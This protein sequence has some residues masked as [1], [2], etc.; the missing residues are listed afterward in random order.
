M[1]YTCH[2][3]RGVVTQGCHDPECRGWQS[4]EIRLPQWSLAWMLDME[5]DWAGDMEEEWGEEEDEQ[6]LIQASLGY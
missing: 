1:T 4:E 2:L 6:F 3:T 5:E